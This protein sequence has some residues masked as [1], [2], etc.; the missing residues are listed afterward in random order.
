MGE[1]ID[2]TGLI[3]RQRVGRYALG[4][5]LLCVLVTLAD[6]YNISVASFAGPPIIKAWSLDRAALGPLLSS[7]LVA[8][9]I[10]PFLFG[11][12]GDRFGRRR[13]I[14]ASTVMIGVFGLISGF[15]RS[16]TPLIVMRFIAGIGM[17]GALAV[18]VALVNEFAPRRLRATFVMLVF[19]GTTI[20]SGLPGLVAPALIA[21]YGWP[22]LFFVGGGAPLLLVPVLFA[23]LP[24]SPKYLALRPERH[25]ELAGVLHRLDG[26][27]RLAPDVRFVSEGQMK[28]PGQLATA[29]LFSGQL[30]VLTPLLW[31]GAFIAML[32]FFSF[33]SWLPTLLTESGVP[34]A[35]AVLLLALFQFVG[36][37]G[38][39]SIMRP[40][41]TFGMIPCTVLYALS[42]P[43]LFALSLAVGSGSALL[44]L[45]PVAGFCILG[46]HF[47]QV[48]C[49]SNIY[50]TQVRA[51][52]VGWFML[53][54]RAGGAVGPAIVTVL[55][56]RH[57]GLRQ[58]LDLATIPLVIGTAASIA[59]TV[60]YN[61]HYH[62]NA[63]A[64]TGL[65]VTAGEP[66]A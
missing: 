13:A 47:A 60:I 41:D 59:V 49:V 46:L 50:P 57:V 65:P 17:S 54:A 8:G 23:L 31:L 32:V 14:L 39:W 12:L 42:L 55:V 10:G 66:Q 3:D 9:L 7:S 21:H 1:T 33:N 34:Y 45:V 56:A 4:V 63:D 40:I 27:R 6:G 38:G 25:G 2:V 28:A 52:G 19:S 43:V 16:L 53:C 22:S 11:T 51:T 26:T 5:L 61:A 30:A 24:E 20:G 37:L 44:V 48:A 29:Q 18:T 64:P 15:C 36:T 35:R 62:R 58:L